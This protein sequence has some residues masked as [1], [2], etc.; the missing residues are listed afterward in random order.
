MKR[1]QVTA[2]PP[3]AFAPTQ[4]SFITRGTSQ[5][6]PGSSTRSISP[7]VGVTNLPKTGRPSLLGSTS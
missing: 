7:T 6:Q 1:P 3:A 2:P 4:A 5:P